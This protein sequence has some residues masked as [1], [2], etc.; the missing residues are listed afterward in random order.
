VGEPVAEWDGHEVI[1]ANAR[2]ERLIGESRRGVLANPSQYGRYGYHR[3]TVELQT[4]GWRFGKD[5]VERIWRREGLKIPLEQSA[6]D[7]Q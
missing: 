1:V 5:L 4:A 3:I 7:R 6:G 2:N